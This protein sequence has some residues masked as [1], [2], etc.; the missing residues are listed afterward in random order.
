MVDIDD[1]QDIV[2]AGPGLDEIIKNVIRE[3]LVSENFT[4]EADVSVSLVDNKEIR[5]L[6]REYRGIDLPTDV[7]S[8]PM[9]EG[10][11][12][13]QISDMPLMLGD[14][15]ISLERALEQSRDYGHSFEREVGYLTAHG[16]LHLLGYDH[17]NDEDREI[18]RQKEE[19]VLEKLGL[20]R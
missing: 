18:M 13:L 20:R 19:S 5:E 6:N 3:T 9:L 8:F 1:R 14:I 15:V 4:A 16:I 10:E 12:N 17:Q 11:D 7:L 2:P